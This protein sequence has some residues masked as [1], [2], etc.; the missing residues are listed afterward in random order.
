[1]ADAPEA[2]AVATPSGQKL[3]ILTIDFGTSNTAQ[4]Y[5]ILEPNEIDDRANVS[6]DRIRPITNYDE[7]VRNRDYDQMR[8]E[9]PTSILY[10]RNWVLFGYEVD[11]LH[12][13][14]DDRPRRGKKK[15]I[16]EERVDSFK[17]LFQDD[18]ETKEVRD[19]LKP[20]VD[21][22]VDTHIIPGGAPH[23]AITADFFTRLLNH[24]KYQLKL[25]HGLE[26]N[27]KIEVVLCVPV[28]FKLAA[29]MDL[30]KALAKALC[31][32]KL[33]GSN[34]SEDW[35][36]R[37]SMITEPE[38][39]AEWALKQYPNIE[40]RSRLL[41]L[42]SGGGT[43]DTSLYET[44]DALPLQLA[45]ED[46]PPTG[47]LCGSNILNS[48]FYKEVL[49]RLN[50]G[51]PNLGKSRD[52]TL[53]D[54]AREI[55]WEQFEQK[56]RGFNM[57]LPKQAF[58]LYKCEGLVADD[59][60]NF[61][62]GLLRVPH[63]VIANM[64]QTCLDKVWSLVLKQLDEA[65][66]RQRPVDTIIMLGGFSRSNAYQDFLQKRVKNYNEKYGAKIV[67]LG[68]GK[69]IDPTAIAQGALLRALNQSSEPERAL[70][71][72]YGVLRHIEDD[73]LCVDY[74]L[75]PPKPKRGRSVYTY[76]DN[77]WWFKHRLVWFAQKGDVVGKDWTVTIPSH[78]CFT[79]SERILLCEELIFIS[80]IVRE[81][82][83]TRDSPRNKGNIIC[84]CRCIGK[85]VANMTSLRDE[86][87]ILP[88]QNGRTQF[89]EVSFNLVIRIKGL[90]LE[91]DAIFRGEKKGHCVINMAPAIVSNGG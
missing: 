69:P 34:H 42:D 39:G 27:Y 18:H 13:S 46:A 48:M 43:C 22:L 9:V 28:V 55:T 72:S 3:V 53:S 38:A 78:H 77:R 8:N 6:P 19:K 32:V 66:N 63:S 81:S 17:L 26:D 25:L 61:G 5:V 70:P 79:L 54:I 47:D 85:I 21:R 31:R 7:D 75:L 65:R 68:I 87:L 82:G 58:T 41:I 36:P 35:I 64:F 15:P 33:G 51:A 88:K 50:E 29:C 16:T 44:G 40:K 89:W 67:I 56:K 83:Y 74:K 24:T 57:E 84:S 20:I 60:H 49:H 73:E 11:E 2:Q 80:D 71:S 52:T 91:A 45:R 59:N 12:E 86:R 62:K 23:V 10:P 37:F 1:M 90:N 76:L 14:A 4:Q 30:Q